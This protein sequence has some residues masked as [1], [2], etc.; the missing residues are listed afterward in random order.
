VSDFNFGA[1]VQRLRDAGLIGPDEITDKLYGEMTDAQLKPFAR[2][3]LH[4]RVRKEL[5]KTRTDPV[6]PQKREQSSNVVALPAT[7]TA[8]RPVKSAGVKNSARSWR[9]FDPDERLQ[10][11]LSGQFSYQGVEWGVTGDLILDQVRAIA[12]DYHTDGRVLIEKGLNWD[13]LAEQMVKHKAKRVR[14]LPRPVL[15]A[16]FFGEEAA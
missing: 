16:F 10:R 12:A 15:V 14:D 5:R 6:R 13:A 8:K 1:E 2:P 3:G 7:G 9:Q 11:K 4:D